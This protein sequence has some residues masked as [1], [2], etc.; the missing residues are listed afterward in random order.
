VPLSFRC[1]HGADLAG[2]ADWPVVPGTGSRD[3]VYSLGNPQVKTKDSNH[4]IPVRPPTRAATTCAEVTTRGHHPCDQGRPWAGTG[5]V[6]WCPFADTGQYAETRGV[7]AVMNLKDDMSYAARSGFG[8]RIGSA[9]S[10][11]DNDSFVI[12][13][14]KYCGPLVGTSLSGAVVCFR[15]GSF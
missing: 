9:N 13:G 11:P 12:R 14:A 1:G 15:R 3:R 6:I 5:G 2:M 8:A 4:H 10:D 7:V